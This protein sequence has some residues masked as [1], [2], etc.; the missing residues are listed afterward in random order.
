MSNSMKS[1]RSM[2]KD[3]LASISVMHGDLSNI[4]APPFVL[5]E[6]STVELPQ[7]WGDHPDLFIAPALEPDAARRA[8]LVLKWFLGSLKNQQYAG[9]SESEGVKKPLNAFLGELFLGSWK[10]NGVK[11]NPNGIG[12][13]EPSETRLISEQVSH[14]PPVT[15][16]YLSNAHHGIHASGFT[17]QEITFSGTVSIKQKGYAVLHIDRFDEDYLIPVPNVKVKGVLSGSPYPELV[18]KY[19][20]V[21]STGFVAEIQFEGK[22]LLGSGL[23]NGFEANIYNSGQNSSRRHEPLYTAKG[24]WSG[25]F[26]IIDCKTGD[27]IDSFDAATAPSNPITVSPRN[28]QDPWESRRAWGDV[29][30]ALD[31]ADMK[32]TAEA[33]SKVEEGQRRLRRE[34]EE[35]G[36][37]WKS[38]FFGKYARDEVFERLVVADRDREGSFSVDFHSGIWKV[39][40][41]AVGNATKP[42]HGGLVPHGRG[43]AR[44]SAVDG[45]NKSNGLDRERRQERELNEQGDD[46]NQ[47]LHGDPED[48]SRPSSAQPAQEDVEQSSG[49]LEKIQIEEFLR[50]RYS[51]PNK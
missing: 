26:G 15:A 10:V 13:E 27:E 23:K 18:G 31:R 51:T 5:G 1:N 12:D 17:Q 46:S 39:D 2:L 32:G 16:C 21:S 43:A 49:Q 28:E 35:R 24:Q 25:Q 45:E 14:H 6:Y 19:S 11:R 50:S 20:I 40:M 38:V 3:F 44:E 7:Y 22:G 33:K 29:L 48:Q 42:Y 4:T 41:D 36:E 30:D 8:V 9:R 47:E 37:E 34:R